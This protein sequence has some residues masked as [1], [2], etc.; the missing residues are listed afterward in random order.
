MSALDL[1]FV[2]GKRVG[3]NGTSD[4]VNQAKA[5]LEAAGAILVER[6]VFSRPASRPARSSTTRPTAT[7]TATT[8]TWART[9][10][11]RACEQENDDNLANEHE[12]LKFGNSTHAASLAI[13]Y[14]PRLPRRR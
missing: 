2:R 10:R 3:W 11:S 7:S 6:A 4:Q 12:A 5:A 8:A 1:N 14:S 9:R 13:D